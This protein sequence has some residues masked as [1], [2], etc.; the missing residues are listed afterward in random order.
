MHDVIGWIAAHPKVFMQAANQ[1]LVLSV[2]ALIAAIA[3]ALPLALAITRLP[4]APPQ[5]R[6]PAERRC[7]ILSL[8]LLR[9]RAVWHRLVRPSSR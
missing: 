5:R 2:T 8:A 3:F 1:H 7:T 9:H 4:R 6:S